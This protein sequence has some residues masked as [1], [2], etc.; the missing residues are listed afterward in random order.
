MKR[1]VC[2]VWVVCWYVYIV[3]RKCEHFMTRVWQNRTFFLMLSF[4]FKNFSPFNFQRQWIK[5]YEFT[6]FSLVV[7]YT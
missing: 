7:C 1:K 3:A 6:A 5:A 4:N 2:W